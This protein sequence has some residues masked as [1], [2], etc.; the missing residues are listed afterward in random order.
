MTVWIL[1]PFDNLPHEGFRP[2]RYWLMAE[3]FARAGCSVKYWTSDFNH[4]TKRRREMSVA[5]DS[6]GIEMRLVPTPPYERNVSLARVRSHK[7][8]AERWAR[9]VRSEPMQD[10]PLAI[11]VST[12]PLSTGVAAVEVA[13]ERGA[14][15]VADMMDEW[16]E[17][18]YRLLPSCLA[19]LGP[20]VFWPQ[21]RSSEKLLR[22]ADFVSGVCERYREK[23][24]AAGAKGYFKAYHGIELRE[25]EDVRGISGTRGRLR[26]V[27]AGNL[28]RTYDIP[29]ILAAVRD[30]ADWTLDVAGMGEQSSLFGADALEGYEG[31]V[32]YHGYLDSDALARLLASCDIGI[33]PM[34]PESC[35]G[36]PYKFGDYSAASLAI[37]SSLGGES[38]ELLKRYR[39]G[40]AY[41]AGDA[42]SL[43]R[44]VRSLSG[45]IDSFRAAS[46]DMAEREFNARRIY[47]GYAVYIMAHAR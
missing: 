19:W 18:F 12:P 36:V 31:R 5:V 9:L 8:F 37:V 34:A 17:T 45:D 2:Q 7:A 40:A 38:A 33:V 25:A 35:V 16:P 42:E 1:N 32:V 39:A 46:R 14:F 15:L 24:L 23:A 30:N 3:A 13:R 44:A 47:D 6:P 11:V 21:R 29:T 27:Y 22:N 43:A 26:L 4:T 10:G 20:F 41:D 28:G